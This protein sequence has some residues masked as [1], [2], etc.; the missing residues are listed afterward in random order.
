MAVL[1]RGDGQVRRVP[2]TEPSPEELPGY[3]YADA[4]ELTVDRIETR[5]AEELTRLAL[6]DTPRALRELVRFVWRAA[7][8][9]EV[10][11][12][13]APDHVVGAR[14]TTNDDDLLHLQVGGPLMRAVIVGRHVQSDRFVVT[15]FISY[16][17]PGPAQAVWSVV[18]PLHRGI[19][20]YLLMRAGGRG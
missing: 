18:S 16:V 2:V 1:S 17:R 5:T 20:R 19:A 3:D 13:M 15:T 9:F 6:E 14:I 10:G 11:P 12:R 7:L 8:Q 4:F